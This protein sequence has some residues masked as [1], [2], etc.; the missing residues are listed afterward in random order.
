MFA[1][2]EAVP[3]AKAE[4]LA[5]QNR[6][7]QPRGSAVTQGAG[8]RQLWQS[9]PR[10]VSRTHRG[11]DKDPEAGHDVASGVPRGGG[12]NAALPTRQ[13]GTAV[14]RLLT[15]RTAFDSD[16]VHVQWQSA[17]LPA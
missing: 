2:V 17:G 16:R 13:T 6:R 5:K 3:E 10:P 14:R 12:H 11:G 4:V 8:R 1:A 7:D 15:G 9:V